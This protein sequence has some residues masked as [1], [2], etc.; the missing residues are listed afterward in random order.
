[1]YVFGCVLFLC[2]GMART[3]CMYGV[4]CFLQRNHQINGHIR[5]IYTD[6]ANPTCVCVVLCACLCVFVCLRD[7]CCL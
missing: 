5:C 4:L 6:L 7:R 2:A 1:V 3:I